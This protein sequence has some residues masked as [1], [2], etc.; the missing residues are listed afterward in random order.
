MNT[1]LAAKSLVALSATVLV[2]ACG[3]SGGSGSSGSTGATKTPASLKSAPGAASITSYLQTSH[4]STL[5]A[6]DTSGNSYVME[7]SATPKAGTTTFDNQSGALSS[8]DTMTLSKNGVHVETSSSE[9]YYTLNPYKHLGDIYSAGTPYAV[10]SKSVDL[11]TTVTVDDSGTVDDITLYHDSS[12]AVV[13]ADATQTYSVSAHD[14]TTVLLCI[15][16]DTT[17]VT[18]TGTAD[19][20]SLGTESDCYTVDAAGNAA[21]NSVAMSVNGE[22]LDF[23]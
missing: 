18:A 1:K 15:K 3:G 6:T 22:S 23:K 13:D 21:L 5:T 20:L 10:A 12:Q 8:A 2:S 19:G 11:P 17:D 16:T 14:A 7:L 4:Q 9:S